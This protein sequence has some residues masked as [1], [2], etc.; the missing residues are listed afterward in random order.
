MQVHSGGIDERIDAA[1]R[2]GKNDT[3]MHIPTGASAVPASRLSLNH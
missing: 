3:G 1:L 2:G